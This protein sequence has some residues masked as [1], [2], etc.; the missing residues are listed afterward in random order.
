MRRY[1]CLFAFVLSLASWDRAVAQTPAREQIKQSVN[2]NVV[3]LMGGLPGATFNQLANDIAVV[4]SD[5]KNLRV[6][7]VEGGAAV[8]NVKDVLYL[9][10]IDMAL[11]TLETMN[12]AEASGELGPN[13]RQR[14]AYIAPLFANPLQILARGGAKS[15]KD[16]NGK[17]VNFNNKGS[18]TAQFV[19]NVFKTLGVNA[20]E[21]YMPQGDALEK[22]RRGELDATVCSCPGT[23]P[24]FAN[25]KP[26]SGLMFVS[27]P[28]EKALQA[29]YLPGRIG[30]EDYPAL[31]E[32]DHGVD[33]ISASTV[34]ISYNW[35][36]NTARY[37]VTAKFI[38]AFFSKIDEFHKPPRSPLW[39]SVNLAANIP[40]WTRF[41]AAEDWL[42]D[43]RAR[44]TE[45]EQ[46]DFKRFISERGLQPS[47][48]QADQLFHDFESWKSKR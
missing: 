10:N 31:I 33:T 6:L 16:L 14:L 43:W 1:L 9:R 48:A 20:Q 22:I 47:A 12:Y 21:F 28:Y 38:E 39:K 23:V 30:N 5:D 27:V 35:A 34:L 24:A 32:K 13:V 29:S 45:R 8:Q 46:A 7:A 42:A 40:G 37:Q 41:A 17:K 18:A 11:T 26:D 4:A 19:P 36:R 15:I 3:F 44:Q 25:V 2:N